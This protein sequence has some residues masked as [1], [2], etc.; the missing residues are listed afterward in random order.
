MNRLH[1]RCSNT[2]IPVRRLDWLHSKRG[3][4]R[5][6]C[7]RPHTSMIYPNCR[8]TVGVMA[9]IGLLSSVTFDRPSSFDITKSFKTLLIDPKFSDVVL[10]TA[11]GVPIRA[12]KVRTGLTISVLFIVFC[13]P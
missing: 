9:E 2:C 4:K 3:K 13:D 7:F 5:F 12:H 10:R 1:V 11:D 8:A 6:N